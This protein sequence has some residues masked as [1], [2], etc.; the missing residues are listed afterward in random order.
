MQLTYRNNKQEEE[1]AVNAAPVY[2][3]KI[4]NAKINGEIIR[5]IHMEIHREINKEIN[6]E[7]NTEIH[8]AIIGN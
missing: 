5:E 2:K 6:R 7:M 4:R 1:G 8:R 3:T